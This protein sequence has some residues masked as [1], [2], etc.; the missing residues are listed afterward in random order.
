MGI[1]KPVLPELQTF[2]AAGIDPKTRL[3]LKALGLSNKDTELKFNARRIFR[4]IDEQRAVQSFK[5][6]NLPE[7]ISSDELER[8]L[9]LKYT[10]VFFYLE[11][12][13][14]FYFL[15][16]ALDGT[17]DVYGRFNKVHPIPLSS[18]G[19]E[20]KDKPKLD[21][22]LAEALALVK[23]NVV[24]DVV[25]FKDQITDEFMKN[26][27]VIIR[28]YTNQMGQSGEPRYLLN[29]H[30]LDMEADCLPFIR[31]NLLLA[32]GIQGLR[33][34]DADAGQ[35]EVRNIAQQLYSAAI[36]GEPYV[37][38]TGKADFQELQ[39]NT[40]TKASEYFLALQSID[41]LLLLTHG[42]D[43]T[44]LYEKKA[45]ILESENQVN[46]NSAS[47]VLADRLAQ[48]QKFCNIVN[49]IFGTNMWCDISDPIAGFD[50][51]A[52]GSL[53]NEDFP[54]N[55]QEEEEEVE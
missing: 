27:G 51:Q 33:V 29:D 8:L 36:K 48:R 37:A 45:H 40:T 42:L 35:F 6:Y 25:V 5:W 31:T 9:Y 10:L 19:V 38:L 15:P 44:G 21:K 39:P 46:A 11:A 50:T 54:E 34:T 13:N 55:S 1:G 52:D 28:D 3:P 20:D 41:N 24:K 43:N 32:T 14:R 18:G 12:T 7:G 47:F 22:T 49:S 2:L 4:I 53:Y 17:I 16:Y 26:S 23:L 30:L